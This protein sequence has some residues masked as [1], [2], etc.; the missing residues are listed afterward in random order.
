MKIIL[1]LLSIAALVPSAVLPTISNNINNNM[2][3]EIK[4]FTSFESMLPPGT[5]THIYPQDLLIILMRQLSL[6][7]KIILQNEK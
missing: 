3:T 2:V 4:S 7:M 5:G 1:S 6:L